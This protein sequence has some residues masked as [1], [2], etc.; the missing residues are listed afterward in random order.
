[1]DLVERKKQYEAQVR[2]VYE[3]KDQLLKA[4]RGKKALRPTI[5]RLAEAW[6]EM[7]AVAYD[8]DR[9]SVLAQY[10]PPDEKGKAKKAF[11]DDY[12]AK[13]GPRIAALTEQAK[14]LET[15]LAKLSA[16]SK[17]AELATAAAKASAAP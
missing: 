9:F 1:M 10:C 15:E 5:D 4:S 11:Y 3:R 2:A 17:A 6:E 16:E 14:Q 7:V 13:A 8:Q 12:C